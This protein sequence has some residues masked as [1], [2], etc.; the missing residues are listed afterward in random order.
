MNQSRSYTMPPEIKVT[1]D[2]NSLSLKFTGAWLDGHP[3]TRADLQ[4]EAGYLEAVNRGSPI[5][6]NNI[7]HFLSGST[8]PVMPPPVK[9]AS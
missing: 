9:A 3:L 1:A 8:A 4:T 5:Y 7:F 6:L 2:T